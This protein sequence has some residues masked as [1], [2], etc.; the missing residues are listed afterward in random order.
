[1]SNCRRLLSK[2]IL[3]AEA[4]THDFPHRVIVRGLCSQQEVLDEV[5]L[6]VPVKLDRATRHHQDSGL[7]LSGL[8]MNRLTIK[9]G[10]LKLARGQHFKEFCECILS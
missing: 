3:E 1:M 7:I 9:S 2:P 6:R 4:V 10:N 5:P 8:L